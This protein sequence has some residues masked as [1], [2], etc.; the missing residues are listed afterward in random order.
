MIK[1]FRKIRYDLMEKNKTG[2]YFKYAI[3]E[4]VLVVIGILIALQINNWNENRKNRIE[5]KALLTQLDSEFKS[6][7]KQ[8][9]QKIAMRNSMVDA[10]L[11]LLD[12]LDHPIKRNNDSIIKYLTPT[13]LVP[14]FD[15]IVNDLISS[16]RLQL[17]KNKRLTELLSLWTS[18]IVQVTEEEISWMKYRDNIYY[19]F[20]VQNSS[21]RNIFNYYW[22]NNTMEA[23]H[24]DKGTTVK[25]DL[26][27]A[28]NN[29]ETS[30][31]FDNPYFE[32]HISV[33]ASFSRLTNSQSESLRKRIVEV[34]E[35]IGQQLND[36]K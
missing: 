16:G 5:E 20:L 1:F 15:P 14:T 21:L 24:L 9:N 3:G 30:K 2:K 19:P 27:K 10:S 7:L 26:K 23:F 18:E 8:L 32:D 28:N 13:T 34:L 11:K 36:G 6:N 29:I 12:Y 22:Q 33:C 31:I 35:I 4:I 25:F 17:I